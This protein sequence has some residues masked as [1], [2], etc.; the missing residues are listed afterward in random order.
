MEDTKTQ[1]WFK[2]ETL[3]GSELTASMTVWIEVD[4]S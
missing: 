1:K 4:L 3:G 2:V